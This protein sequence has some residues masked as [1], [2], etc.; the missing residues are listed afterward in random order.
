MTNTAKQQIAAAAMRW[1][2]AQPGSLI[3]GI[4]TGST[5]NELIPLLPQLGPRLQ[6][7]TASSLATEALLRSHQLPIAQL[8]DLPELPIYLDGADSFTPLRQLLKGA[9][10]A[11]TREKVL[12][13]Y[14]KYFVCLADS[15]KYTVRFGERALPVEVIPM[16]RSY[17]A[18]ALL[19]LCGGK[20][21]LRDNFLTD[22]GNIVLDLY[23]YQCDQPI[24]LEQAINN[25]PGVVAN[26]IFA[27]RHADLILTENTEI[28]G[29]C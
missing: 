11:L 10:G 23:H 28:L 16:A 7:T 24:A 13:Y 14:S 5:V 4:G 25:I 26:G 9:G 8:T 22:N 15:K 3:L 19:K 29:A 18:R 1:L 21:V 2:M 12:A 20:V 17:V 6:V 27:Q